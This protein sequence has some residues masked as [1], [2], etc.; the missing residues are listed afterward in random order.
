MEEALS[1]FLSEK[2]SSLTNKKIKIKSLLKLTVKSYIFCLLMGL[3]R[4]ESR[5]FDQVDLSSSSF[6]SLRYV[7]YQ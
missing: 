6:L 5:N 2:I 1:W 4:K 7:R 3:F